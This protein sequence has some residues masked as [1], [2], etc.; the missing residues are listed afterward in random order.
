MDPFEN[1]IIM[2]KHKIRWFC[3]VTALLF[4]P[5]IHNELILQL[6]HLLD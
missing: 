2:Y 6:T 5:Q 1:L 3:G 4:G